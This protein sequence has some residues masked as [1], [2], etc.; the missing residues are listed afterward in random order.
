MRRINSLLLGLL[1]TLLAVCPAHASEPQQPWLVLVYMVGSDLAENGAAADDLQEMLT[2]VPP[3]TEMVLCTGGAERWAH[4]TIVARDGCRIWRAADGTLQPLESLGE[5]NMCA[6]DTLAAFLRF[7][8]ENYTGYRRG[9]I[10]WDHGFGPLGGFGMDVRHAADSLTLPELHEA[11]GGR[12]PFAFIG[13]DACFMSSLE[14][15]LTLGEY[16]EYLVASEEREAREG[17]NYAFLSALTPEVSTEAACQQ[18]VESYRDFFV[19]KYADFP[20]EF[21]EI[22]SLS[23]IRISDLSGV[24]KAAEQLFDAMNQ[25]MRTGGYNALARV[26]MNQ[27]SVGR[28]SARNEMGLMDLRELAES[29][30][31]YYPAEAENLLHAL[32]TAVFAHWSSLPGL[33]GLSIFYPFNDNG[34]TVELAWGSRSTAQGRA[35]FSP[36]LPMWTICPSVRLMPL[37]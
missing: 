12:Q 10:L 4:E 23:A 2:A 19:D 25:S 17:W 33:G 20:P 29:L 32:E 30:A 9:L 36:R 5:R 26:R 34:T 15:A 11:F 28:I 7:A 6:P 37:S 27:P 1:L 8:E 24:S 35:F 22:V 18:M 14:V 21:M 3:Q 16:T 13:L 31:L